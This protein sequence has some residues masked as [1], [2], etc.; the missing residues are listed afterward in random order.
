[1]FQSGL[2]SDREMARTF[3]IV[4]LSTINLSSG[5]QMNGF[6]QNSRYSYVRYNPPTQPL[7]PPPT[8]NV[9]DRIKV[10]PPAMPSFNLRAVSIF[11]YLY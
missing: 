2:D 9:K 6:G 7:P 11:Y 4:V 10:Q 5:F 3:I 1:M 8:G